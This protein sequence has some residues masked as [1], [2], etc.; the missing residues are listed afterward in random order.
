M[1]GVVSAGGQNLYGVSLTKGAEGCWF[2]HSPE[3]VTYMGRF[4]IFEPSEGCIVRGIWLA[5][6]RGNELAQPVDAATL[7]ELMFQDYGPVWTE[8][9]L[10]PR[11][12]VTVL[13][14]GTA[15]GVSATFRSQSRRQVSL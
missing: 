4:Q 14:T 3:V 2:T 8:P 1:N 12:L 9:R 13:L 11:S 6:G 5:P 15:T 7:N 10:L